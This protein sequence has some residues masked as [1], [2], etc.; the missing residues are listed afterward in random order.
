MLYVEHPQSNEFDLSPAQRLFREETE[1]WFRKVSVAGGGI[2]YK[3]RL[4]GGGLS[5]LSRFL[6]DKGGEAVSRE[7]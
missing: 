7:R 3:D 6:L 2:R 1:K 5:V 4:T